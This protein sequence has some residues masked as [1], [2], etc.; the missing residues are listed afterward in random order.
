MYNKPYFMKYAYKTAF[1]ANMADRLSDAICNQT[2]ELNKRNGSITPVKSTSTM[3]YLLENGPATLMELSRSLDYSHQL[4]SLRLKPLEKLGLVDRQ[5]D[6][7][8]KRKKVIRLTE[9]GLAD[10]KILQ[11]IC[12]LTADLINEKFASLNVDL[13]AELENMLISIEKEPLNSPM[14]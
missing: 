14:G 4:T 11:S 7:D 2:A 10:A 6:E 3:L 12:T 9:E 8:D 5:V 13:M 1:L